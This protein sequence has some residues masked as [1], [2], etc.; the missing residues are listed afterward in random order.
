MR[1]SHTWASLLN[2]LFE[3][4][5]AQVSEDRARGFVGVLGKRS[6]DL[7]IHVASDHKEVRKTIVVKVDNSCSPTN[8]ARFHSQTR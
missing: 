1:R 4:A 8:V 3:H 6:F 2:K 5:F 7:R